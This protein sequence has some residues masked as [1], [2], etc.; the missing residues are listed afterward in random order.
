MA[1]HT[2]MSEGVDTAIFECGIGGEYDCTNIFVSPTVTGITSLGIDHVSM[3]GGT[4][5]QIAWH[6]AGIMKAG[7]SAFTV[8][9]TPAAQAVLEQRAA[10][11]FVDL[12]VVEHDPCLDNITLGLAADFQLSNASLAIRMAAAH[13]LA[14]DPTN[15]LCMSPPPPEFVRGLQQVRWPGRCETRRENNIIW[16]IDGGH[17]L[18]SIQAAASWFAS[19]S[20][21]LGPPPSTPLPRTR[22]L[23][24][25]QQTRDAD[26]LARILH[27]ALVT[28]LHDHHPFSHVIF[29]TNKTFRVAGFR[30]DLIS[31][32]T[33]AE[34][35]N[36]LKVQ[37]Q[38]AATWQGIDAAARVEVAPSIEEA[39]DWV[40][41][42]AAQA[43]HDVAALVTGSLHLVGGF[44][45][46]LETGGESGG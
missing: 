18:E 22:I 31:M 2:Y 37:N 39:V 17:T 46:V 44:L 29:C 3:L 6:K 40:R 14:V 23:I 9:Q 45:E 7:A 21:S 25:N 15:P 34:A 35:V 26:D 27:A 28:A 30:P 19:S 11:K 1:L 20:T 16:H 12:H 13:L 10:A 38:L 36:S 8:L 5:E 24:F 4:I 41:E 32:N 33:N 43:D 42:V